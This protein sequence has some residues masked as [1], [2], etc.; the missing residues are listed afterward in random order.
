M[1]I[2]K[3]RP[4]HTLHPHQA[5][6]PRLQFKLERWHKRSIY[7][8]IGALFFS[9]LAWIIAR[10]TLRA[11]GEFGETIHPLEHWSIQLHG[12]LIVPS[13][14]L[15]GSLLFQHMRRAH[16][17]GRNRKSG[18]TMVMSLAWL[19]LTGYGLYYFA[20]ETARPWWSAAHWI[21]GCALP[22]LLLLHIYLGRLSVRLGRASST[23]P[24]P[25][26]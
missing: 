3:H 14:F 26:A 10:F 18:W 21:V 20:S 13:A 11:V 2:P 24:L 25:P 15:I 22:A 9:G 6:S 17:A 23:M 16:H 8:L 19:A 12:A 4:R 5:V 7:L 1:P